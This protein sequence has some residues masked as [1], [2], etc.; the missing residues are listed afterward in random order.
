VSAVMR[1][2]HATFSGLSDAGYGRDAQTLL[3]RLRRQGLVPAV[4]SVSVCEC[5]RCHEMYAARDIRT[6]TFCQNPDC[7]E[8]WSWGRKRKRREQVTDSQ[9]SLKDDAFIDL[10]VPGQIRFRA[11]DKARHNE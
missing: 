10:D 8:P 2:R 6:F 5:P 7:L 9:M 1:Q 4:R 11:I 3:R